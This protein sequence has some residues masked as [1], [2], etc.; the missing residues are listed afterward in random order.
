[1]KF[2]VIY[3]P[4]HSMGGKEDFRVHRDGCTDI[5]RHKSHPRFKHGGNAWNTEA[6]T[7]E[8]AVAKEVASF[9]EQDMDYEA[10]HFH[11]CHCCGVKLKYVKANVRRT[12]EHLRKLPLRRP[13]K[14]DKAKVVKVRISNTRH[15]GEL[16]IVFSMLEKQ[17]L[18]PINETQTAIVVNA[19]DE[20]WFSSL[21][22]AI[23]FMTSCSI[24]RA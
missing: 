14:A 21:K 20:A 24:E 1:M 9:E 3:D 22:Q 13:T 15:L 5:K 23:E 19:P 7:A 4:N 17:G 16:Q 10:K 18:R 2:T 6:E 12:A 11:I 8:E